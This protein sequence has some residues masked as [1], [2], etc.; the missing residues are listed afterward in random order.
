MSDYRRSEIISGLFVT[1]AVV[2]F[3][4]FA[5]KVGRFDL[6]GLLKPEA[7][8]ARAF[9][10]DV[11]TIQV[12]SKVKVGGRE[13]GEITLMQWVE[14][15]WPPAGPGS[16]EAL[17]RL[18]NEV[19]FE[20]TGGDL[21]LDLDTAHVTVAQDSLLSPHFLELDPGRWPPGQPPATIFAADLPDKFLIA[22][23]ETAGVDEI[24]AVAGPVVGELAA[25]LRTVN[26]E[27]LTPENMATARRVFERLDLT[28]EEGHQL[29]A[30]LN[31]GVLAP[32][33]VEAL[34]RM[35]HNLD[36]AV[37]DGQAVAARVDEILD[38]DR[39]PSVDEILSD[40]A[41][42]SKELR[43]NLGLISADLQRLLGTADEVLVEARNELAETSRRM[44]RALWQG[45]LALRKIRANPAL[46]LFGDDETDFEAPDFDMTEIRLRGRA[47]PYG[48]RDEKDE[49]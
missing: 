2:V 9:L 21:R 26:R 29:A 18:I 38:P 11:K 16:E 1:A 22:S 20:L 47:R 43:Q 14:G 5:F 15:P 27:L 10:L 34:D 19:S 39:E 44:R 12:G 24:M 8:G 13:V 30:S 35:I 4:L 46:L 31:R 23:I 45:E 33:N 49:N 32:D 41:A 7:V 40:V 48:Q 37:A 17:H 42:V 28:L 25:M 6:M 36:Q 3:A